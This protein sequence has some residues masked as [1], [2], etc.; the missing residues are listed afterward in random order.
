MPSTSRHQMRSQ[1]D[2]STAG[3]GGAGGTQARP[4]CSGLPEGGTVREGQVACKAHSLFLRPRPPWTNRI[5]RRKRAATGS[6]HTVNPS[7]FTS[8]AGHAIQNPPTS[9]RSSCDSQECSVPV[10]STSWSHRENRDGRTT[11]QSG[12]RHTVPADAAGQLSLDS[13]YRRHR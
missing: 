2:R 8:G 5:R 9:D 10:P 4:P 3:C 13:A 12:K 6:P 11:E 1:D 7:G